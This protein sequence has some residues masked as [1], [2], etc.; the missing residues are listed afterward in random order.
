MSLE[1]VFL[2]DISVSKTVGIDDGGLETPVRKGSYG[3]RLLICT[4]SWSWPYKDELYFVGDELF[5]GNQNLNVY[6]TRDSKFE[7]RRDRVT[8]YSLDVVLLE[9]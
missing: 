8:V 7:R 6:V 3:G 2:N 1:V 4:T 5:R 9:K